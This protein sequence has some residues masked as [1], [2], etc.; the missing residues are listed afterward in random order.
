MAWG[1][2]GGGRRGQLRHPKAGLYRGGKKRLTSH[3]FPFGSEQTE[4]NKQ[5]KSRPKRRSFKHNLK[6]LQTENTDLLGVG[7]GK[8]KGLTNSV[9][10]PQKSL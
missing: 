6:N 10:A 9:W 4:T 5:A 2:G 7:P 1:G 8:R 3:P